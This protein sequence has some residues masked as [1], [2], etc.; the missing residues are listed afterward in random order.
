[1]VRGLPVDGNPQVKPAATAVTRS[2]PT[3][4]RLSPPALPPRWRFAIGASRFTRGVAAGTQSKRTPR[5]CVGGV[6]WCVLNSPH[7]LSGSSSISRVLNEPSVPHYSCLPRS[8]TSVWVIR[9]PSIPLRKCSVH[10]RDVEFAGPSQLSVLLRFFSMTMRPLPSGFHFSNAPVYPD[11]T[12]NSE[13]GHCDER[14][15]TKT[16]LNQAESGAR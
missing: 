1:M 4:T 8:A 9:H 7:Q 12:I 13:M 16:G 14:A 2:T 11:L 3:V 6:L 15:G 5:R 10:A